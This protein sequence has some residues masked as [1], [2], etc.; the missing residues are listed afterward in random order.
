VRRRA[1]VFF[2]WMSHAPPAQT[3]RHPD[4]SKTPICHPGRSATLLCHPGRSETPLCHPGRSATPLCHPG[5]SAAESRDP[6][7]DPGTAPIACRTARGKSGIPDQVRVD[8]I[9][10][11]QRPGQPLTILSMAYGEFRI[12]SGMTR[13]EF[14]EWCMILLIGVGKAE[15]PRPPNRT[16]GSPAY[17]S[18]V[19]GFHIGI[20]A[21]RHGLRGV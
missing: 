16:C 11:P 17:G 15:P 21:P 19:S 8:R 14:G 9:Q 3:L 20:D 6:K 2:P 1:L 7:A 5:R 12:E 4:R 18:P 13:G 10:R